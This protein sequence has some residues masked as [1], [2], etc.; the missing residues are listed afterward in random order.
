MLETL[1]QAFAAPGRLL[2]TPQAPVSL[3]YILSGIAVG[4][5]YFG[6]LT[7][8][9]RRPEQ[10]SVWH[11]LFPRHILLHP[12]AI[13]DYQY[14]F[15]SRIFWILAA[16]I[17]FL[18]SPFI[19]K[20]TQQGL[21]AVFGTR[22]AATELQW[23]HIAIATCL[24]VVVYDFA[25]WL[26][27]WLL[28]RVP[29]LWAIHKG[30]HSAEVLTPFTSVRAHPLEEIINANFTAIGTGLLYGG[31]AYWFGSEPRTADIWH[32]NILMLL[33][34]I[35]FY[36]LRHSH[37]WLPITGRLGT[38]IQ[39]PAHHQV[40][41]S[42]SPEHI[43]KNFGFCLAIW[44]WLFGTLYIPKQTESFTLGIGKQSA[45][46]HKMLPFLLLPFQDIAR[47]IASRRETQQAK[48]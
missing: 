26:F 45:K 32:V 29:W 41:H 22:T 31:L 46:Y 6:W 3:Y 16:S 36:N 21:T 13:F 30:H 18:Q 38:I 33:Y 8:R 19:A 42:T 1:E 15:V 24:Y 9:R 20:Q 7:L 48:P 40:H 14:F 37:I 44:D 23:W 28:H 47:L 10:Q 4:F 43:D 17:L 27:H 2:L 25:Y 35:V 39:S 12:S 34:Y 11:Y 5:G